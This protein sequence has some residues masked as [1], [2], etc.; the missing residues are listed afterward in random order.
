MSPMDFA[1]GD[2][3]I[4][5]ALLAAGLLLLVA[6]QFVRV[7]YPILLVLGG[8]GIA[9]IPGM[10][11]VELAPNL[12][13]VAVLPPL[14]YGS[15]FFTSLREFRANLRPILLLA[16]GLVLITMVAVAVAV[17]A[18]IPGLGWSGAFVL[19]ALVSPT[20]PT[21]ATSIAQRLGLP[22]RL[23]AVIEGESLVNDGTALVALKFAV[24]AVVTGTFSLA[25]ATG[26]FALNVVGG[27]AV[28]LVVGYLI[29]QLRRRVDNPP[30]EITIS[31]LSGY[32][33]YLPARAVGVS[34]VI[35]AVTVGI[36]M[37]WHTPELTTAQ[38]RLQ[39][40][41]V[42]EI[43]FLLLNALLF[44]L[45]GLQLPSIVDAL[46]AHST[47]E[48]IGY[49]ALVSAVVIAARFVWI[50]SSGFAGHALSRRFTREDPAPSWP[51]KTVLSWSGMRG[52]VSLAAAL[53]IP[54]TIDSGASFPNRSLIIFLTF[55]VILVT[56]VLQGLTLPGLIRVLDLED[57]GLAE[58]EEAKARIYAAQAAIDRLTELEGEEWV[59]EDTAERL[60]GLYGFRQN[61]FRARFDPD[62]DGSI[63]DRSQAYQRLMREL[64]DA[65]RRAVEELRRERRIDDDVMRRVVRDLDLEES[66]LDV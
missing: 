63:E 10:P 45:V 34:G 46:S 18:V 14:L 17:H 26:E 38:V 13:L 59:R 33:G 49:A 41:A 12:V 48:L 61:R 15:A 6:S 58:Q 4:L 27:I 28:G 29:R 37:G 39:G 51:S 8:L 7:P 24:A 19:G 52:A 22:R 20:D 65:E 56:L 57:D 47:A 30:V 62:G 50:F 55:S 21:A 31:L 11:T 23:I 2:N 53:A 3:A 44:A 64:I 1:A 66:R 40:I 60:R 54:L 35:A 25:Q 5:A 32:F 42:W 43:V 9:L 36:Y 16:I